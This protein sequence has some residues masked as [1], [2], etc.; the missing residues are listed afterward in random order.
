M[1][2][3][4]TDTRMNVDSARCACQIPGPAPSEDRDEYSTFHYRSS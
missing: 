2:L 1:T 4:G 3:T